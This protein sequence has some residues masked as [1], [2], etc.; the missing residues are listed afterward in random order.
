MRKV[1]HN[2]IQQMRVRDMLTKKE[3][4]KCMANLE[5]RYSKLKEMGDKTNE[6][7]EEFLRQ[8]ITSVTLNSIKEI[9]TLSYKER[10]RDYES[11]QEEKLKRAEELVNKYKL[12]RERLTR[13][14]T[15]K[16]HKSEQLIK[17][18]LEQTKQRLQQQKSKKRE[19]IIIRMEKA[20]DVNKIIKK[21]HRKNINESKKYL[22]HPYTY[23]KMEK[24]Y[25][26]NVIFPQLKQSHEFLKAK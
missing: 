11:N 1:L 15:K 26:K 24:E 23:E 17:I 25:E 21:N 3:F 9:K 2:E 7:V 12:Q 14:S 18:K 13:N 6:E 4:E 22:D 19:E 5:T 8:A 20:K 10:V 16:E